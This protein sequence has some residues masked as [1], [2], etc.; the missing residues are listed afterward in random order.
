[1]ILKWNLHQWARLLAIPIVVFMAW[2]V[3]IYAGRRGIT[4][5]EVL[6]GLFAILG[7]IIL[8]RGREGLRIGYVAW[9][10]MLAL[11]YRTADLGNILKLHPLVILI[12]V[13]FVI[14]LIYKSGD[15]RASIRMFIPRWL[16]IFTLFWMW[17]FLVALLRGLNLQLALYNVFSFTSFIPLLILTYHLLTTMRDWRVAITSFY[18][19]GT[20]IALLGMIEFFFPSLRTI[21][22]GFVGVGT[23]GNIDQFGFTRASFSF[24]GNPVAS[25][26]CAVS[27]PF[28]LVL[29]SWYRTP[30]ARLLIML[31]VLV[32]LLGIYIGGYRSLWLMVAGA[33]VVIYALKRDLSKVGLIV[34]LIVTVY[35]I[36]PQSGQER[37]ISIFSAAEGNFVDSSAFKR[38]ERA[39]ISLSLILSNPFGV[40]LSGSGWVHSDILQI[41]AETGI[42]GGMVFAG[43]FLSALLRLGRL[44]WAKKDPLDM[45]LLVSMLIVMNILIFQTVTVLPQLV[46]PL[47]LVWS[48]VEV[49][50]ERER[51]AA[52]V[53]QPAAI[54]PPLD[55]QRSRLQ[56]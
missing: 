49:R 8:G 11:G 54:M 46:A 14:L 51:L 28:V 42:L 9:I 4:Y 52:P 37:L 27:L 50:L 56:V 31:S 22:P 12:G 45:A 32:L 29:R 36:T 19:V 1:M 38:Y 48:W 35:V 41:T 47:W 2:Q 6:S 53:A 10:A 26:I 5:I 25:F 15:Q 39:E 24:Y 55:V 30:T 33:F 17:G 3:G 40:G 23:Y 18:I 20:F 13:L 7:I 16:L 44:Y 43:G 34:A 21:L